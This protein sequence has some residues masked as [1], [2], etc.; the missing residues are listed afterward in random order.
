MMIKISP[1]VDQ[2]KRLN[3]FLLC[4]LTSLCKIGILDYCKMLQ[5]CCFFY[6]KAWIFGFH[7]HVFPVSELNYTGHDFFF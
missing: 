4:K 7:F 6:Q 3:R 2:Y 5:D 1:T